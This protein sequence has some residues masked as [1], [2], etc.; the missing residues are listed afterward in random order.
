MFRYPPVF[1]R[2]RYFE[3]DE[4]LAVRLGTLAIT[5]EVGDGGEGDHRV[6][7]G[8]APD[9]ELQI[10]TLSLI[11]ELQTNLRED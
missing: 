1:F 11:T 2:G 6:R 5:V 10:N 8:H 7:V 4:A 9:L 3:S